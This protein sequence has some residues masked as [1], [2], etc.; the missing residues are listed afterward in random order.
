MEQLKGMDASQMRDALSQLSKEQMQQL[1]EQLKKGAQ[2][3]KECQGSGGGLGE[4]S[5]SEKLMSILREGQGKDGEGEGPGRGGISRGRGDAPM[6]YGDEQNLGA[7]NLEGITNTDL[8]RAAPGDV[9]GEGQTKHDDEEVPVK[10]RQ[11]GAVS[12]VGKGGD[13][14][15][16]ESLMPE[17]KAVLKKYF[18]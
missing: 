10:A 7:G 17:E 6:F 2:A 16:R 4:I 11:A 5:E 3:C 15:W 1:R 8:S 18:K 9:L 14:V 12:G 13:A